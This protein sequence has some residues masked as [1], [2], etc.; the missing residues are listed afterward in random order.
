M[1]VNEIVGFWTNQ[2]YLD[3]NEGDHSVA[4]VNMSPSN[5]E[6]ELGKGKRFIGVQVRAVRP[7]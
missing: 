6:P 2:V 5:P 3:E 7:K 1:Y 4:L